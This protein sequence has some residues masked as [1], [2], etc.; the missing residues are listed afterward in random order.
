MKLL[1]T[2]MLRSLYHIQIRVARPGIGVSGNS[3]ALMVLADLFRKAK[4]NVWLCVE[5]LTKARIHNLKT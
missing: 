5:L 4:M 2:L 3:F 1:K